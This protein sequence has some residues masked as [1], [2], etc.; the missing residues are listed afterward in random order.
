M[1]D[2]PCV[3]GRVSVV[4]P[5]YNQAALLAESIDSVL[6][7]TYSDLELIVVND[8][9][10]DGVESV[11]A[12]YAGCPRVRLLTQTNQKL[13]AA[14]SNGFRFAQG[15]FWTWTSA[16]NRMH[17][18]QL[19]VQVAFLRAHPETAMVY[20]DYRA[21]DDHGDP[22][23]DP[24]FRPQNRITSRSPMIHLPRS[25]CELNVVSD[26]FI[27]PCF[28]Y[29]GWVG[30]LMGEYDPSMGIEDYDYWMRINSAFQIDH[31][32]EYDVLYEYRVHENSLSDQLYGKPIA[33]L[34]D[35][36][37]ANQCARSEYS[38]RPWTI[39]VDDTVKSLALENRFEPHQVVCWRSD[40]STPEVADGRAKT[41][42]GGTRTQ[43]DVPDRLRKPERTRPECQRAPIPR[44]LCVRFDRVGL[45]EPCRGKVSGRPRGGGRSRDCRA[46]G[47]S[48]RG[49]THRRQ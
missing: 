40:L 32:G 30:R 25:T 31:L 9:S 12:R 23:D 16:D 1:A 39:H 46:A 42:C 10:T 20:A 14:L 37:I 2:F 5:V 4:L 7:Q 17:Q 41:G 38:S 33:D 43:G 13:P 22:L 24:D 44:G 18:E 35:R 36:L 11:L 45:R 6:N 21:I 19:S 15:E 29:R 47:A 34:C 48:G 27:G 26:N 28:L 8:G 49:F 3:P